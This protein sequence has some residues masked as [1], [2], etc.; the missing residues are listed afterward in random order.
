[1]KKNNNELLG[2]YLAAAL[3]NADIN[4]DPIMFKHTEYGRIELVYD[5]K[6]SPP[7]EPDWHGFGMVSI[8]WINAFTHGIDLG[9]DVPFDIK[10]EDNL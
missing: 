5:V 8:P 2:A 4:M 6:I 7:G 9:D 1:M 3:Y 10:W